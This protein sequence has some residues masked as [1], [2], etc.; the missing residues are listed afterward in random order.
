[1]GQLFRE[2][3]YGMRTQQ[4]A[5]L[6]HTHM[7]THINRGDYDTAGD[8][9]QAFPAL[10]GQEVMMQCIP[11]IAKWSGLLLTLDTCCKYLPKSR[12]GCNKTK[13]WVCFYPQEV[14]PGEIR[15]K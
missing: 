14:M 6:I 2:A 7:D 8:R 5:L 4:V 13:S 12:L 3:Y 11:G 15:N 9:N 10:W 1:M